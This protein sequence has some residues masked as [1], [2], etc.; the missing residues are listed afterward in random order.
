M[1][2]LFTSLVILACP[3]IS[4]AKTVSGSITGDK[5]SEIKINLRSDN[6]I[7]HFADFHRGIYPILFSFKG[8]NLKSKEGRE[9]ILFDLLTEVYYNGRLLGKVTRSPIPYSPGEILIGP[10]SFDFISLLTYNEMTKI[11]IK[12]TPGKLPSGRYQ[13][14][15]GAKQVEFNGQIKPGIFSF[16]II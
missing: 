14:K 8:E 2:K 12:E 13:V 7:D 5:S 16:V 11:S 10:E 3:F 6:I 15:I 4:I 1:K 9:I